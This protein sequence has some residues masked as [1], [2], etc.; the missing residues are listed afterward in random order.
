M[1][2]P[3]TELRFVSDKIGYGIFATSFI[4]KGSITWVKDELDRIITKEELKKFSPENLENLLKYT[5]RN[6]DGDYFFCWDLTRYVNHSFTPNSMLTSLGFEIAIRDI[7]PGEEMTNDY[8]TL[9]IIEAFICANDPEHERSHVYPDDLSRYHEK[10]DKQIDDSYQFINKIQ[11]PLEK[12][13]TTSQKNE[14][15][16]ILLGAVKMPS[17]IKNLFLGN[18]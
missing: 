7:H 4:P 6:S 11:Q 17:V 8:G 1:L 14:I 9:N 16:Q 12:L 13:L 5:Y 2:H 18:S 15:H 3:N 10:W